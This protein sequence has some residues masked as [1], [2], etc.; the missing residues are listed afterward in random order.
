MK[1]VTLRSSK[2]DSLADASSKDD[3]DN[4]TR[5]DDDDGG[6]QL[7]DP[8]ASKRFAA[9]ADKSYADNRSKEYPSLKDATYDP[10]LSDDRNIVYHDKK[11]GSTWWGIRG[12]DFTSP[13]DLATDMAIVGDHVGGKQYENIKD[14]FNISP[15]MKMGM[16]M[17]D[18]LSMKSRDERFANT[19][20]KYKQIRKK[21]S[22]G[23]INIG[24]HSLGGA[25]AQHLLKSLTPE[26]EKRVRVHAFNALPLHGFDPEKHIAS[27][28]ETK[29]RG[30]PVSVHSVGSN[31]RTVK[32]LKAVD[33]VIKMKLGDFQSKQEPSSHA[34][35]QFVGLDLNKIPRGSTVS[36]WNDMQSGYRGDDAERQ[37]IAELKATHK[38]VREEI[39]KQFIK[40]LRLKPQK[41]FRVPNVG[42]S[43][44]VPSVKSVKQLAPSVASTQRL[45]AMKTKIS[46]TKPLERK[47]G[48]SPAIIKD[49]L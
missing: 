43:G 27:Y 49:E 40:G 14:L 37:D 42:S 21:Y 31:V 11:D 16:A 10:A 22:K 18:L 3:G 46:K 2:D 17:A 5:D 35:S 9:V 44:R 38:R 8:S 25:V 4:E 33:G 23:I 15:K 48:K 1:G 24:A 41:K 20:A 19:E 34:M 26:E 36:V 45:E 39:R 47:R 13:K 30:D 29:N 6:K 28:Y 7:V 12:T 32:G